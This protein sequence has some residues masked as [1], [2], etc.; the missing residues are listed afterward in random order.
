MKVIALILLMLTSISTRAEVLW[1]KAELGM[2]IDQVAAAY[3]EATKPTDPDKYLDR[4]PELLRVNDLVLARNNFTAGFYFI[5]GRLAAVILRLAT[6]PTMPEATAA[7]KELSESLS[8]KYGAPV[9]VD[10]KPRAG[11]MET[12]TRN[13]RSGR[14][15]VRLFL[16][17]L[18]GIE[19]DPVLSILYD[20][21]AAEDADKL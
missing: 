2:T 8:R 10:E 7:Y 13:W 16:M 6:G 9:T 5:D 14:V 12:K 3:P 1:G 17:G 4:G 21:R 15:G 19:F 18:I 20:A 11:S